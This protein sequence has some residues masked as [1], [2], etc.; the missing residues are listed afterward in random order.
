MSTKNEILNFKV[1]CSTGNI[2]DVNFFI[3][4]NE[5][6]AS[7]N[8]ESGLKKQFCKHIESL[9]DKDP[10]GSNLLEKISESEF[11]DAI[12][13]VEICNDEFLTAKNNLS[14]AKKHLS[15]LTYG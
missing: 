12:V 8:C 3:N 14:K 13:N 5:V 15:R 11:Y 2:Y 10:E 9:V 7:C 4:D 6:S 1:T